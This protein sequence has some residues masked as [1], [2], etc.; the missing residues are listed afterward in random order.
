MPAS[1]NWFDDTSTTNTETTPPTPAPP[2]LVQML[3]VWGQIFYVNRDGSPAS[4][5]SLD[6]L[7]KTSRSF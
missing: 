6:A 4:Q 1:E 5:A 3:D 2:D 7:A